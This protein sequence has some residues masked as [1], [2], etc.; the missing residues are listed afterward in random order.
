M[1]PIYLPGSLSL[2]D[3]DEREQKLKKYLEIIRHSKHIV[4]FWVLYVRVPL[5]A[6]KPA[7]TFIFGY[8][9]FRFFCCVKIFFI[10][11]L[12]VFTLKGTEIIILDPKTTS[13]QLCPNHVTNPDVGYLLSLYTVI[14]EPSSTALSC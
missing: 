8:M 3:K 11:L 1:S 12:C 13:H 2:S 14:K 9:P 4:I 7:H 6:V 10:L 5:T